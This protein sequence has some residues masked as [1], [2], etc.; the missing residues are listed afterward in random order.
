MLLFI[1]SENFQNKIYIIMS[2]IK[3]SLVILLIHV[4]ALC[5]TGQSIER[6]VIASTGRS[7]SAGN[8]RVDYT[9]GEVAVTTLQSPAN[10]LTQGFHQHYD[11]SVGILQQP[12]FLLTLEA[13]PNPTEHQLTLYITAS[14]PA[15]FTATIYDVAGRNSGIVLRSE[16]T[17]KYAGTLDVSQLSAGAY[18]I[19]LTDAKGKHAGTLRFQKL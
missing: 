16:V 12:E 7:A 13:Y 18:F 17:E 1:A 3:I 4:G 10:K 15:F 2:T 11:V 9:L 5:A 6:N 8:V 19:H 14:A